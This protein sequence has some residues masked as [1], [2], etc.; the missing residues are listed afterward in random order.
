[1]NQKSG[2]PNMLAVPINHSDH[3]LG[4]HTARVN[5]IAQDVSFGL[6]PLQTAISAALQAW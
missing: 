6:E 5:G 2:G 3:F 1:M 4:S